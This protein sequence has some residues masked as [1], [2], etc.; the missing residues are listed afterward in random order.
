MMTGSR[1]RLNLHPISRRRRAV[2]MNIIDLDLESDHP[3]T[4]IE[5]DN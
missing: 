4:T 2:K 1:I 3:A 5:N